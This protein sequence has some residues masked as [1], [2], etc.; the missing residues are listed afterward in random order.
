V[1]GRRN[2]LHGYRI[3]KQANVLRHFTAQLEPS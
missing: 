1:A 2:E 3:A